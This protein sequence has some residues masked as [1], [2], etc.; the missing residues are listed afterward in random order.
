VIKMEFK[1]VVIKKGR[2]TTIKAVKVKEN[3]RI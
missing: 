2:T 3:E 1:Y